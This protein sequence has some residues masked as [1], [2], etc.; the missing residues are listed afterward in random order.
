VRDRIDAQREREA[1]RGQGC[2]GPDGLSR[3]PA[4]KR[5][6]Q[7]GQ[8]Q[9]QN[10]EIPHLHPRPQ[11][12]VKLGAAAEEARDQPADELGRRQRVADR[13][14]V[15]P[16]RADRLAR[17][18]QA[19][20][21]H[22]RGEQHGKEHR[23]GVAQPDPQGAAP[24]SRFVPPQH[25]PEYA[26]QPE[27]ENDEQGRL[28]VPG[29]DRN[30]QQEGADRHA[31]HQARQAGPLSD[32]SLSD[33]SLSGWPLCSQILRD[34]SQG[35]QHSQPRPEDPGQ[36]AQGRIQVEVPEVRQ[37]HI[38]EHEGQ[39][40]GQCPDPA[41]LVAAGQE[42]VHAGACKPHVRHAHGLQA[43]VG[44]ARVGEEEQQ[45]GRIEESGLD[46]ADVRRAAVERWIPE[47]PR[48]PGQACGRETVRRKEERH[49]VA[50]VRGHPGLAR[51]HAPEEPKDR[52]SQ[53][54]EAGHVEVPGRAQA[55]PAEERPGQ[56]ERSKP[57]GGQYDPAHAKMNPLGERH[58]SD[59]TTAREG[60]GNRCAGDERSRCRAPRRCPAPSN[61]ERQ[62][63]PLITWVSV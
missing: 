23:R 61:D 21:E 63:R 51:D 29:R 41:Q 57:D 13:V 40:A 25:Q 59:D 4:L 39:R 53:E 31:P 26:E 7:A 5:H 56:E 12:P 1:H 20:Q 54:S 60:W 62:R 43:G 33:W 47:R 10:A 3:G 18:L 15:A 16:P 35:I 49:Q 44:K 30:C 37:E 32:Q 19:G 24:G 2:Q 58:W 22:R 46:V 52:Q 28:D 9:G 38:G 45:V 42:Q 17:E 55:L 11:A 6:G 50:P 27:R 36:P 34:R 14:V 8:D 48:A